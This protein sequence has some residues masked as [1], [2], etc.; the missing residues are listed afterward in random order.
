MQYAVGMISNIEVRFMPRNLLNA[1]FITEL[2]EDEFIDFKRD[3]LSVKS[4]NT[5]LG[6][7]SFKATRIQNKN[8]ETRQRKIR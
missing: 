4:V 1:T 7:L 2:C 5:S 8:S 6:N 3:Y